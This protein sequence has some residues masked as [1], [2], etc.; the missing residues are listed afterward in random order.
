MK[1]SPKN[2]VVLS[3]ICA[4]F[5]LMGSISFFLFAEQHIY[6]SFLWKFDTTINTFFSLFHQNTPQ[7]TLLQKF[8]IVIT[9]LFDPVI[10]LT[11]FGV[12]LCFLW[13]KKKRFEALFLFSGVIIGQVIK[14]IIKILTDRARPENPF[15]LPVH[16]S[17]FPSGHATTSVFFFLAI[18][19][20]FTFQIPKKYKIITIFTQIFLITG[21]ILIPFSR[22]FVQV[23]YTSDVLAGSLLGIGSFAIT[24]FVF[25]WCEQWQL[26][27]T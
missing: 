14:G 12:L 1:T 19:Y 27:K 18:L 21:M 6:S 3:I 22:I 4:S 15:L 24:I 23:H 16:E 2:I 9:S 20:L 26:K 11:W 7:N 17:S 5:I 25:L 8:F 13:W 10:F